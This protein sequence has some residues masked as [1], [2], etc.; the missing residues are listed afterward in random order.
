MEMHQV[1][2]IMRWLAPV[3]LAASIAVSIWGYVRSHKLPYLL[4]LLA[5]LIYAFWWGYAPVSDFVYRQPY[6]A[7]DQQKLT[8]I[9][10][11]IQA[12]YRKYAPLPYRS[13]ALTPFMVIPVGQVLI[14]AALIL[15]VR[16][17]KRYS[18]HADASDG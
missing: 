7:E 15:L 12:V 6:T 10:Q 13:Y 11:E 17:E 9:G 1:Y 8:L 5:Y 18:E 2:D 4:F 14:L 3:V 16:Q